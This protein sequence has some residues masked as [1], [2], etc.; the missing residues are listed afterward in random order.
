V[1]SEIPGLIDIGAN[2]THCAFKHD[3]KD[4]VAGAKAAELAHIILT[5]TDIASSEAAAKLAG[6]SPHFFSSTSGLHPHSSQNVTSEDFARLKVLLANPAVVA[7][8]ETGL[9]F[10]R[11]YSEPRM[12]RGVFEAHLELACTIRKPLFL[13]QRDA[14]SEF[15]DML[16]AFR[17]QI[18]G[19]V[20]HCFTD[21]LE[22]LRDYLNLGMYIGI[23]GWICDERRGQ[24][25]QDIV[26]YVPHDRLL[27]E[28]DA[29]Y[30]LPR[31]LRK[32]PKS[33]RNEPKYLTEVLSII[34][35]CRNED[36]NWLGMVTAKNAR[37]LFNLDARATAT[38]NFM[39]R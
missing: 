30:L 31:T 22:A 33:R 21:S 36:A 10:N 14:H 37:T 2:L 29:P 26:N 20:V 28:T 16:S 15:H 4:V 6:E 11:N 34:A 39:S 13:H 18:S 17:D 27:I 38:F 35:A 9:D 25:L 32:K 12:Q 3:F 23:T 7:I 19:G 24:A 5:G 8:G 1:R